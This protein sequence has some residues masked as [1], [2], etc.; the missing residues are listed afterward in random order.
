MQWIDL[1]FI[2]F[3]DIIM[4]RKC[5]KHF[6]CKIK[7]SVTNAFLGQVE[8]S[9]K[10]SDLYER[11]KSE[12]FN[13]ASIINEEWNYDHGMVY[14]YVYIRYKIKIDIYNLIKKMK[15]KIIASLSGLMKK[16]RNHIIIQTLKKNIE[17]GF[18]DAISESP[19]GRL[20]FAVVTVKNVS[21]TED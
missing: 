20:S 18:N 13:N 5:Y 21:V 12:T 2:L 8:E 11:I 1:S 10:S 4:G 14:S 16:K 17:T 19:S 9:I 7:L 3:Y 6:S 15:G